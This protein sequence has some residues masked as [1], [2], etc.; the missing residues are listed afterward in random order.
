MGQMYMTIFFPSICKDG[1]CHQ[2]LLAN[3]FAVN[4][5]LDALREAYSWGQLKG[6]VVDV[7][8]GSGKVS[9]TLAQVP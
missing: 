5:N 1:Q 4:L 8:G 7:G 6:T 3:A 2:D 9:I